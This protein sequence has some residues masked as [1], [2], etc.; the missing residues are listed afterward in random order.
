[1]VLANGMKRA[2]WQAGY[3]KRPRSENEG[4]IKK[5]FISITKATAR[6]RHTDDG[7][8]AAMA[9]AHGQPYF[10]VI[11]LVAKAVALSINFRPISPLLR[12]GGTLGSG[13]RY[14]SHTDGLPVS[15]ISLAFA[16]PP[17][18]CCCLK[19]LP[20]EVLA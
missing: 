3:G 8:A 16:L 19:V 4:Q 10:S 14:F 18:R 1:M 5:L 9:G 12:H 2:G 17:L 13:T 6:Q 15:A 7:T 20:S 11:P